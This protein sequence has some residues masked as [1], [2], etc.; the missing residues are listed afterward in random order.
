MFSHY[1]VV[2]TDS[3]KPMI[4]FVEIVRSRML[5][6]KKFFTMKNFNNCMYSFWGRLSENSD[7]VIS[8]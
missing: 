1:Q 5:G 2:I 4:D 6:V 3:L 8:I 7:R